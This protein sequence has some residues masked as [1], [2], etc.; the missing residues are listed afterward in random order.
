ME[1]SFFKLLLLDV[2]GVILTNGWDHTSRK[3]VADHFQID[4][5]ELNERHDLLFPI[6]EL[7]KI[8][9]DQYLTYCV[10]FKSRAFAPS[11][12]KNFMYAQSQPF[13]EM[14]DLLKTLKGRKTFKI[15]LLSNE[16]QELAEHRTKSYPLDQL[17][18]FLIFSG[19]VGLRKPDP[20]IYQLGLKLGFARPEET[21]YVD[22]R[23][24]LVEFSKSLG[25]VGLH[26][27]KFDTIYKSIHQYFHLAD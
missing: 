11:D 1:S 5:Q 26:Y 7:G 24:G 25:I 13:P 17:V 23:K 8:S 19:D 6:Y 12:F 2:G 3:R 10:F 16:G 14:L 4:L 20:E 27:Q 18:D 22:D 15:G 9:L 21:I